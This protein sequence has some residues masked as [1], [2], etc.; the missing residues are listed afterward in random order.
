MSKNIGLCA[1]ITALIM[2]TLLCLTLQPATMETSRQ[3]DMARSLLS[4]VYGYEEQDIENFVFSDDGQGKLSYWHKDHPEWVYTLEYNRETNSWTGAFTPFYDGRFPGYPGEGIIRFILYRAKEQ[5]WFSNWNKDSMDA[6]HKLIAD[7]GSIRMQPLLIAGLTQHDITAAQAID[8]FFVSTHGEP[9]EWTQATREWRNLILKENGLVPEAPYALPEGKPMHFHLSEVTPVD[10]TE[11]DRTIPQPLEKAMAHPKLEGWKA[12]DGTLQE[13]TYQSG[14]MYGAALAAYE[15]DGKRL[16]V[17]FIKKKDGQDYGVYPVSENALR[18]DRGL[19]IASKNTSN[20]M[21]IEYE[22]VNGWLETFTVM[23]VHYGENQTACVIDSY[24]NYNQITGESF[25]AC[26]SMDGWQLTQVS[27]DGNIV[28]AQIDAPVMGYLEAIDIQSFPTSF[29]AFK[30]LTGSLIPEG[31]ALLNGVN[32]RQ[33][34]S[35][36]S[37]SLGVMNSGTLAQVLGERPGDP[38]PWLHVRVGS[39]EG[40]VSTVYVSPPAS[41]HGTSVAYARNLPVGKAMKPVPLMS[42]TGWFDGKVTDL[43]KGVKFHVITEQNGWLYVVVPRGEIGW[44]MDAEG[45]YGYVKAGDVFISGSG[46]KL[47]WEE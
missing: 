22:A 3:E 9:F 30:A 43:E 46:M 38:N 12:L 20:Q 32:L 14:E 6:M 42:G 7:D 25:Q 47:D 18:T 1:R 31:Y 4:E 24:L 27:K 39:K 5:K 45:T 19:K 35:S 15:K 2:A 33:K 41:P 23:P 10:I 44:F 36:R 17:M 26:V 16:L 28:K 37:N 8:A 40:Y 13:R 34:T 21:Q 11:F 29:Q